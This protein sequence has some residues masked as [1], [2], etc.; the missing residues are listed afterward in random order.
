[1]RQ[2]RQTAI[3]AASETV[4]ALPRWDL[5]AAFPRIDSDG[6][7]AGFQDWLDAIVALEA[8]FDAEQVGSGSDSVSPKRFER[9][10]SA[11]NDTLDRTMTMGAYLSALVS[12]NSRDEAAQARLSQFSIAE[13][14]LHVLRK[15][16][17]AWIGAI[18]LESTIAASPLAAAHT[19]PLRRKSRRRRVCC[20]R[21]KKCWPRR[22]RRPG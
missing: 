13:T 11:L 3:D 19:F 1:M 8:L 9:V 16:Y 6:F 20:R 15:R 7:R 12:A 4:D 17:T 21:R 18:D 5:T 22:W 10:L 14:R 2:N